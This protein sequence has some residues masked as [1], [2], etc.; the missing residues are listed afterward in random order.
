MMRSISSSENLFITS[1][2]FTTVDDLVPILL[3][4][5]APGEG[6]V[7]NGADFGG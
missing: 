1:A 4:L 6:A 2:L 3:P 5:L 7:T